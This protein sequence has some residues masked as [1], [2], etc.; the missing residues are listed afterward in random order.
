MLVPRP[1]SSSSTRLLSDRLL[2]M[3]AASFISTIK[4]DSPRERLSDAPT[5]VNILSMMPILASFAGTKQPVCAIIT[6]RAVCLSNADL[7]D[8]FGPVSMIT[9]C[10]SLSSHTSLGT[11]GSSGGN[12]RSIT[13]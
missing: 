8:I 6:I 7:P 4:V 2:R 11:Y 10:S 12:W 9:C 5:L 13:G 3:L 1:I